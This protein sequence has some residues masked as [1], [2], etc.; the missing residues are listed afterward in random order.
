MYVKCNDKQ[1]LL[2]RSLNY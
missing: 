1:L 2:I